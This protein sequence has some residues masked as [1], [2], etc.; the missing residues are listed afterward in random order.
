ML[1]ISYGSVLSCIVFSDLLIIYLSTVSKQSDF[2]LKHGI[3]FIF[4]SI[5]LVG[6]RMLFPF[7][8]GFTYSIYSTKILTFFFDFINIPI[9][10]GIPALKILI[11][12][13][14]IGSIIKFIL[15]IRHQF[16]FY[17]YI[18]IYSHEKKNQLETMSSNITEFAWENVK[19]LY[20]SKIT[21][22]CVMG[23]FHPIILLPDIEFESKELEFILRH[24]LEHLK[25]H[26][27]WF[28]FFMEI[29]VCIY[30]MNPLIYL[31]RKRLK[32]VMEL[33]NDLSITKN[34]DENDKLNYLECLLKMAKNRSTIINMPSL[35]FLDS[36]HSLLKQ[37]F[38][39]IIERKKFHYRSISNLIHIFVVFAT[40]FISVFIVAEPEYPSPTGTVGLEKE[41]TFFIKNGNAYD[42]YYNNEYFGPVDTL[43]SFSGYRIYQS[44]KE[45]IKYEKIN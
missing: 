37:R 11:A 18:Y 17:Q 20:S 25:H 32:N 30:W 5:I 36:N 38:Q 4:I 14:G 2:I 34:M 27:L 16:Y 28:Q 15:M 33:S 9:F 21:S 31:L 45:A 29:L 41:K 26:D 44:K 42:I 35:C 13:S 24:E 39:V 40:L 3:N 43:D 6:I 7:N 22:P 1:E 8:F 12:I 19:I 10:M 23:L